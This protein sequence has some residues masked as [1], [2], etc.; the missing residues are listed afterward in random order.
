M[1]LSA[2][3]QEDPVVAIRKKEEETR[4]QFLQNPVQLKKLQ[5]ALKAREEQ[6]RAKKKKKK[7]SSKDLDRK[8]AEKLFLL[9]TGGLSPALLLKKE[10][11]RKRAEKE[12][13][14]NTILMHKFNELKSKLTDEDLK[15]ILSGKVSDSDDSSESSSEEEKK[16]VVKKKKREKKKKKHKKKKTVSVSSSSEEDSDNSEEVG[17]KSKRRSKEKKKK[18]KRIE[19]DHKKS[20]KNDTKW[21]VKDHHSESRRSRS[22]S[23]DRSRRE[24]DRERHS[25]KRHHSRSRSRSSEERNTNQRQRGKTEHRHDPKELS[26]YTEERTFK[27]TSKR[28][29]KNKTES[30]DSGSDSSSEDNLRHSRK[31]SETSGDEKRKK[32]Q[33][34]GLVKADGSKIKL[35][36]RSRDERVI[37][38]PKKAPDI[39]TKEIEKRVKPQNLTEAEKELRRREMMENAVWRDRER[40]TNVKRYRENDAK[41][42]KQEF[43]PDFVHKELMKSANTSTVESR[44]KANRNNIQRSRGDMNS[45]FSRRR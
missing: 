17:C 15:D 43:D 36:E 44:I 30:S 23:K 7:H 20:S 35:S 41:E 39:L 12:D 37:D 2:K 25:K 19:N 22:K 24:T 40:E 32:K 31:S 1:D 16:K 10:K 3:L 38:K 11:E 42:S 26:K 8:I 45:H 6:M 9:K 4:R 28:K 13:A 29:V 14:L 18:G 21:N 33:S 34:W 27:K 5:E